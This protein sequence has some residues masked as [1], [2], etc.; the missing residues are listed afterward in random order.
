M[1]VAAFDCGTNSLRLLVA[2]VDAAAGRLVDVE[3]RTE[4]VRLGQGVDRTG[5][6]TPE[7]MRRALA[8]TE[9][10][11]EA[12]RRHGVER[13]RFAATSASRDARNAADFVAGVHALVGVDPEVIS[14]SDEA[15][16]SFIASTAS[17]SA[18]R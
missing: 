15:R 6:I 2:D 4:I 14:G 12:C 18:P 1:R 11:A 17:R 9:A 5:E 3:R 7:A 8:V 10:Y 13:V 16:L